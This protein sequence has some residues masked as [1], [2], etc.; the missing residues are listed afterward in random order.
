MKS[1]L[2]YVDKRYV[3]DS[4]DRLGIEDVALSKI[5]FGSSL[6]SPIINN[7]SGLPVSVE[8]SKWSV[9]D[10]PERLYRV[11]SFNKFKSMQ[12]FI[13]Q[14]MTYQEKINHHAKMT[15]EYRAVTITTYTHDLREVT[16][17]DKQLAAF[18]DEIYDDVKYFADFGKEDE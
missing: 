12:Y 10:D 6:H 7:E 18:A 9:L 1:L 15:I 16:D 3:D 8:E 5:S 4:R 17:L 2:E 13:N 14:M 11:F